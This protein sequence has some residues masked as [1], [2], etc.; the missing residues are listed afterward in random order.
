MKRVALQCDICEQIIGYTSIPY[1]GDG[2]ALRKIAAGGVIE[3]ICCPA[4]EIKR[5]NNEGIE[6]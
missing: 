1:S 3:P 4:C 5:I 6:P 2:S